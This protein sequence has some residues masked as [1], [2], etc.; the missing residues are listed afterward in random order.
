MKKFNT[1]WKIVLIIFTV[2]TS[3]IAVFICYNILDKHFG[4]FEEHYPFN[5]KFDQ[6]Y[7]HNRS[8]AL[9]DRQTDKLTTPRV[10][11][12]TVPGKKDTLI[13][14]CQHKKR[15]YINAN[16]GKIVIEAK[17]DYAWAFAEGV[18]AVVLNGKLGFIDSTEHLVIP[19]KFTYS[20]E[21][22]KN[23]DHVFS[24]GYCTATNSQ[25]RQGVINK[26]GE[27]VISPQY[28]YINNSVIGYRIVKLNRKYGLLD[29][30]LKL[31]LP[32]EYDH[33]EIQKGG[34]QIAKDGV[35]Q[36][37]SFDTKTILKPFVYE[38]IKSLQYDSGRAD[39]AGTEIMINTNCF[40]YNVFTKWGLMKRDGT[41]VTKAIYDEIE[42]LSDDLFSCTNESY[43][44][45][46]SSKGK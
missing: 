12:I 39:S 21:K 42:G 44:L 15:G 3:I 34:L 35:Q 16:T 1:F 6:I 24:G 29:S 14:F 4:A 27:W 23:V 26:R 28:D 22:E 30:K 43:K 33:I 46:I 8:Y 32:V 2:S 10:E 25:G 41:V 45:T 13:V 31:L 19:Y 36:L 11:W 5:T 18:G 37:V 40:A 7:Y 17:Y 20:G 9:I 38:M